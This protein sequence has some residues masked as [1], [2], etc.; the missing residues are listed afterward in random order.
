MGI[1]TPISMDHEEFLGNSIGEIAIE[2]AGII[3]NGVKM[4]FAKQEKCVLN[5]LKNKAKKLDCFTITQDETSNQ[6][7][8]I[9][10]YY[11]QIRKRA[12]PY[13]NQV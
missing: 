11:S 13:Q 8:I 2:K 10:I 5:I 4:I 3:K 6:N 1:I 9:P 12:F 7:V